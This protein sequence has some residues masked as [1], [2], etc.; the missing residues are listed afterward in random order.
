[1]KIKLKLLTKELISELLTITVSPCISLYMPTHRIHPENIQDPIR[2]KNLVK[3][4]KESLIEKY[5]NA[6]IETLLESFETLAH[7]EDFWNHTSDGLCV[8]AAPA[9]FEVIQLQLP[10]EELVIIEE[11]F[12]S[13]PLRQILQSED[14]YQVLALTQDTIHLYEGNRHSLIEIKLPGGFPKT[15]SEAL[16]DELTEKHSTV[17]S[18]GGVGSGSTTIH[19]GHGGKK[20][21]VDNDAE[22]FFRLTASAIYDN[23]SNPL[24]LPL[25]LAALPEHHNLFKQ[26]NKN[27]FLLAEGIEI[28]PQAVTIEKLA[29]LSWEIMQPLYLKKLELLAEKFNQAKSNGLGSET[30]DE[31]IEAAE[32]S[33]VD[34]VFIEANRVIAKRLRNKVTGTFETADTTQPVLDDQLDDIGELVNKMGGTVIIIPKEQMPSETGIAAIFRY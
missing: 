30:I 9:F 17:A 26:V 19:H 22:R 23:Y 12:H 11:S 18:Y 31:V 34:T 20:D 14:R 16:G 8:L 5:P 4:V 27:P 28:N 2:Y 25:L 3:Q 1:M 10:V 7:D 13:K 21:E 15:V 6:E 24:G 33:R 32:A 29:E